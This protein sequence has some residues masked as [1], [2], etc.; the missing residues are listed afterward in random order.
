LVEVNLNILC[1]LQLKD[2]G[3]YEKLNTFPSVHRDVSIVLPEGVL[4]AQ[5]VEIA[6]KNAELL[7]NITLFDEYRDAKKLGEGLKNLAFH[8]S[9]RSRTQTL[10][11]ELVEA[12]FNKVVNALKSDLGAQLRMEFDTAKAA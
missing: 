1:D 7:E 2:S 9:F 6:Q 5:V 8:L 11:D 3:E 10:T 4:M 12:D